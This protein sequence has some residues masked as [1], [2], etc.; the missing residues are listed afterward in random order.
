MFTAWTMALAVACS[1]AGPTASSELPSS[2]VSEATTL[3]KIGSAVG[4]RVPDFTLSLHDGDTVT[5][6]S[7]LAEGRPTFLFFFTTW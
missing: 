1:S 2:Q 6:A 5:T 4:D 3:V 7:L